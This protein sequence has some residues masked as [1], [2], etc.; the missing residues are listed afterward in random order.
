MKND[1]GSTDFGDGK[2]PL[3]S[4]ATIAILV[5]IL[6]LT[7]RYAIA[8][9]TVQSLQP[10]ERKWISPSSS[11]PSQTAKAPEPITISV[12][13]PSFVGL[14][15][16]VR[17]RVRNLDCK[18]FNPVL[19]LETGHGRVPLEFIEI[20][21]LPDGVMSKTFTISVDKYEPGS[22]LWEPV[23]IDEGEYD[24]RHQ[25]FDIE[26]F[27]Y[28]GGFFLDG[29][30]PKSAEFDF[31]CRDFTSDVRRKPETILSCGWPIGEVQ[32]SKAHLINTVATKLTLRFSM[33]PP[34]QSHPQ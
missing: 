12:E 25:S 17:Y 4:I 31:Q 27:G 18:G 11:G 34:M 7:G 9:D 16:A 2:C 20:Y 28:H 6:L 15:F 5:V 32:P 24:T 8:E 23:S 33:G 1:C 22:C 26:N 13:K 19:F 10:I 3:S 29:T 30:G 14:F 21:R